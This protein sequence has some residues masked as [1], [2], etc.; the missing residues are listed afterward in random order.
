MKNPRMDFVFSNE[1]GCFAVRVNE[2]GSAYTES[3]AY[4][5]IEG[6]KGFQEI[7]AVME[8]AKTKLE[9]ILSRKEIKA[10]EER[11]GENP[12]KNV[13]GRKGFFHP[14]SFEA[15]SSKSPFNE[16]LLKTVEELGLSTRASNCL[17]YQAD[18]KYVSE[19][20]QKSELELLRIK[21]FGKRSLYEV[22]DVLRGMGLGFGMELE[23]FP[24]R[25]ALDSNLKKED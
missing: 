8:M 5:H 19:L 25:E 24:S 9:E 7:I 20:V 13:E 21:N 16:N 11:T 22:K 3:G 18:I 1:D 12:F 2:N 15:T 14:L 6:I 4:V 23:R 17:K 10:A